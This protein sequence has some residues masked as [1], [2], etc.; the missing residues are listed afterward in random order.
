MSLLVLLHRWVGALLALALLAIAGSGALL[1]FADDYLRWRLPMLS[2]F[3]AAPPPNAQALAAV[4]QSA[5]NMGGTLAFPRDTLPAYI[6]YLPGGGQRLHHP[7]DGRTLVEWGPLDT[8]PGV[9]FELHAHLLAGDPG[10]LA[11]G[12]LALLLLAMLA[13]GAVLWWRL[14]RGLPLRRWLPRSLHSRELLRSHSAQGVGLGLALGFMALSGAAFVFHAEAAA[15]LNTVLGAR[16]PLSPTSRVLDA[17]SELAEIDWPAVLD[18]AKAQFPDARLRM[19][20]LPRAP[21]APLVLRLKREA[22]LHPNGRSY[23][24]I[25]PGSGKVLERIDA[26]QTGLGPA[27]LNSFYP[28]HAGKSGWWGHRAALLLLALALCWI[29]LSGLWLFLRRQRRLGGSAASPA[30]TEREAV[31]PSTR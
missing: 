14:R 3:E 18:S 27:V 21:E 31:Q 10:Q 20:T 19:L 8:L 30:A 7:L 23:L 17:P 1:L 25:D 2:A 24:S 4:V 13:S 12:M 9:L 28:L 6:H 11:L 16:G 15:V 22:E 5:A 29:S 26:T